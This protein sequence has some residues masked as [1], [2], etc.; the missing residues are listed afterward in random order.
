[1][2][3]SPEDR[4]RLY[5]DAFSRHAKS[6][7]AEANFALIDA[8]AEADALRYELGIANEQNAALQAEIEK[9]KNPPPE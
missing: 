8:K 7:L 5:S 9:L 2:P 3:I 1:M 4:Q 6:H